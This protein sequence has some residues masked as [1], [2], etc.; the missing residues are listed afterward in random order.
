MRQ[1][2]GGVRG[3]VSRRQTFSAGGDADR[4]HRS[5]S[6]GSR[7]HDGIRSNYYAAIGRA[8]SGLAAAG[9]G[10]DGREA[11]ADEGWG[12]AASGCYLRCLVRL[13]RKN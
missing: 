11:P 1:R 7:P 13:M 6:G 12:P 2:G 8:A 3:G 5:A 9:L 4:E 10:V